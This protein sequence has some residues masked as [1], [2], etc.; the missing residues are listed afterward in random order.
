MI[1]VVEKDIKK[2]KIAGDP[3]FVTYRDYTP[4]TLLRN[5]TTTRVTI[6]IVIITRR[7]ILPVTTTMSTI[8]NEIVFFIKIAPGN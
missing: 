1:V 8:S 4:R 7:T 5:V 6:T 2:I 3:K